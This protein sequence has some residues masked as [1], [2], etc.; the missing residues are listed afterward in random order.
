MG[1]CTKIKKNIAQYYHKIRYRSKIKKIRERIK[2]VQTYSVRESADL[3]GDFHGFNRI[4][5]IKK[6]VYVSASSPKRAVIIYMRRYRLHMKLKHNFE[7]SYY[8]ET[9]QMWGRIMVTDEKG[10]KTFWK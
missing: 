8:N 3:F 7:R 6:D 4:G 2:R 1:N 5:L 10:F 9:S